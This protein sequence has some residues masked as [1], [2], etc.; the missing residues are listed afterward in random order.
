MKGKPGAK[1]LG[2]KA[3]A[4][5]LGKS[6]PEVRELV[7]SGKLPEQAVKLIG[8]KAFF[9]RKELDKWIAAR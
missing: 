7:M 4:V 9:V 6:E 3:A 8:G 5:Y 1:L 2:L